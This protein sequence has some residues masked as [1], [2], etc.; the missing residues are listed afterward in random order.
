MLFSQ[1]GLGGD[2]VLPQHRP[3]FVLDP[4]VVQDRERKRPIW[5]AAINCSQAQKSAPV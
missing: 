3:R 2:H 5:R 4:E 1:G